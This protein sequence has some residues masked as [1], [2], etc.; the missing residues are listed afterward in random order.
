MMGRLVLASMLV[1]GM[2]ANCGGSGDMS[3]ATG[4]VESTAPAS[5]ATAAVAVPPLLPMVI[6]RES[7][8]AGGAEQLNLPLSST[9][10]IVGTMSFR[11]FF[12]CGYLGFEATSGAVLVSPADGVITKQ[13][14]VSERDQ[15]TGNTG[16]LRIEVTLQ[17]GETVDM[18]FSAKSTSSLAVGSA[19]NRGDVIGSHSGTPMA[20]EALGFNTLIVRSSKHVCVQSMAAPGIWAGGSPAVLARQ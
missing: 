3:S 7:I 1:G 13:L 5:V 2:V 10:E 4:V 8:G 9:E 11:H 15:L 18:Y 17:S 20:A 19:V 12:G 16:G 6:T 14:E